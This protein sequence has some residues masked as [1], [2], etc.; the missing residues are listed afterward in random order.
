[1]KELGFT[2]QRMDCPACAAKI[3]QGVVKEFSEG[4]VTCTADPETKTL[5]VKAVVRT[6][7]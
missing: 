2:V 7:S 3:R 6:V 5:I 1:M 4:A